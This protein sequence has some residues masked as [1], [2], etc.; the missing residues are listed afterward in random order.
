M[1][2]DEIVRNHLFNEITVGDHIVWSK[3]ITRDDMLM[4]GMLSEN[5]GTSQMSGA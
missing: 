2:A 4:F 5:P 1:T 3:T